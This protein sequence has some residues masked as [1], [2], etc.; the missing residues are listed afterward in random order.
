MSEVGYWR[1]VTEWCL[2]ENDTFGTCAF[3]AIG[4]LHCVVTTANGRPEVM[5]D[6]EI[7]RM[8]NRVTGFNPRDRKTDRGAHLK[9]VLDYWMSN[10]WAGDP[11]LK[12]LWYSDVAKRDI[13]ETIRVYGGAYAW[14]LL[15][16][17]VTGEPDFSDYALRVPGPGDD[18]HA[19][20][21][22]GA[23][24][25]GS[26]WLVTWKRVVEVSVAWWER[27]GQEQFAVLHPAWQRPASS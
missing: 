20:L 12:P 9:A 22:V 5:S 21:I 23:D 26:L 3:A 4:N 24:D 14:C 25:E 19:V 17:D 10:G 6:G 2:G 15:P 27:Y 13:P 16:K 8:D 7:E 18:A 11:T 1:P